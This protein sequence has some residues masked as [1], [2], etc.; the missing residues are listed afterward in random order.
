MIG[1]LP[2]MGRGL[3]HTGRHVLEA[4]QSTL[5]ASRHGYI[6]CAADIIPLEG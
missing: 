3:G 5:D 1:L 6:A 2:G 4:K